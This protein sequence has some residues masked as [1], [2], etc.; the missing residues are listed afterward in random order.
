MYLING[1][2][3]GIMLKDLIKRFNEAGWVAFYRPIKKTVSISGGPD[4]SIKEAI[5]IMTR[6]LKEK[7]MLR[8]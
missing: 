5:A 3:Q 6:L 2:R 7:E 1:N 4:K 8:G